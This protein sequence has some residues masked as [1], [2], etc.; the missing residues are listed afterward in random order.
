MKFQNYDFEQFRIRFQSMSDAEVLA[1]YANVSNRIWEADAS[2]TSEKM[3]CKD[4]FASL[5]EA[6]MVQDYLANYIAGL[7]LQEHGYSFESN[8][9]C[10]R[11]LPCG[12]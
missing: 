10:T 4:F 11:F 7:Y 9:S 12:T 8:E 1:E 5:D 6:L 2:Y 3:S